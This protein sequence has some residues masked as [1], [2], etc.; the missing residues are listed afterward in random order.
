MPHRSTMHF[1]VIGLLSWLPLWSQSDSASYPNAYHDYQ[2]VVSQLQNWAKSPHAKLIKYGT[3]AGGETLYVLQIAASGAIAPEKRQ[4]IFIGANM[5]GMHHTGTEA[6]L[7]LVSNLLNADNKKAAEQIKNHTYYI[8]PVL[9]PD[10]HG[11]FFASPR[12]IS[13]GNKGKLDRDRDGFQGEDG[14]ND[15]NGD[16]MITKLRIADP[17][18]RDMAEP[19]EAM[20]MRRADAK[21]GEKGTH[22]VITE[23][24]DDDGDGQF[25]E[26]AATGIDP[27]LNFAHGF[28]YDNPSA[29]PWASTA[30]EAKAIMDFLLVRPQIAMAVLYDRA[31]YFLAP[32]QGIKGSV[33]TGNM[34]LDIPREIAEYLGFDPD[35]KYSLDEIWEVAKNLPE[36]TQNNLSKDDVAQFLGVG[37][38][39]KPKGEDLAVLSFFADKYKKRLEEAK[40]DTKRKG[41]QDHPGG[42]SNWLYFHFGAMTVELDIWGVPKAPEPKKEKEDEDKLTIDKLEK[43]SS[44][45]FIALGEEKIGQFMKDN[46]VPAQY[47]PEAVIGMVKGG[48]ID[49]KRIAGMLKQMGAGSGG[50]D[51]KDAKRDDLLVF[52]R[53]H[54]P[55]A[56]VPWTKVTLKDGREAEVGGI[57]SYLSH[58]PPHTLLEKPIAAH[59]DTVL[60]MVDHLANIAILQTRITQ[61]GKDVFRIKVTAGNTEF[62]P[63]HTS[64]SQKAKNRLPVRLG[65]VESSQFTLLHGPKWATSESLSGHSA[66]MR[67]EWVVKANTKNAKIKVQ[68]LSQHAG[69]DTAEITLK[70]GVQ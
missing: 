23:G 1:L 33:D 47:T 31:N 50:D 55:W 11:Y 29:G 62:M 58:N 10:T 13:K 4:A 35:Q 32:P 2:E 18:G 37:P 52:A 30:P 66:S 42:F 67:G 19:T 64:L 20:I 25:N 27:S 56:V 65:L 51:K 60:E 22:F 36:V 61:L 68:L 45:D 3:S 15:M 14:Y 28:Q 53:E 63:T 70:E 41:K 48:Q 39:T 54:A 5:S 46:N 12:M 34:K 21:E 57:D 7:H 44:E 38:A 17:R 9:N 69:N 49:P 59:T 43:M 8:V 6:A 40:L 16:G 26:D 24:D